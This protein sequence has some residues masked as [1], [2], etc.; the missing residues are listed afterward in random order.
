[1]CGYKLERIEH[2][3]AGIR[4]VSQTCLRYA[5]YSNERRKE[6]K[7][8]G[9]K[10]GKTERAGEGSR[11]PDARG[12]EKRKTGGTRTAGWFCRKSELRENNA[13]QRL[14]RSA[15][16]GGKLARRHGGKER[17]CD[18]VSQP[19]VPA[20]GSARHLQPHFLHNGG[21]ADTAVYSGG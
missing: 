21:K 13:V 14:Y 18:E 1:M 19:P 7:R 5:R 20:G 17:G 2:V 4:A 10:R 8:G 16:E 3:Q 6:R 15:A 9:S 12:N 11:E